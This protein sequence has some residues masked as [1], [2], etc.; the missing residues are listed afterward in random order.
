MF[1]NRGRALLPKQPVTRPRFGS[2]GARQIRVGP[3]HFGDRLFA[4]IRSG[5]DGYKRKRNFRTRDLKRVTRYT[6][7]CSIQSCSDNL[8]ESLILAQDERWRR[9]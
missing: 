8:L 7:P 1:D 9:A 2:K 3:D 4:G 5:E 6:S